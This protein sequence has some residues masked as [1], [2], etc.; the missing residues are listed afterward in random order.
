MSFSEFSNVYLTIAVRYARPEWGNRDDEQM[1]PAVIGLQAVNFVI[2]RALTRGTSSPFIA[3][4]PVSA[5]D[6]AKIRAGLKEFV[7]G[8]V[9][10]AVGALERFPA[11]T[12]WLLA[13]T[14]A[15]NYGVEGEIAAIAIWPRVAQAFGLPTIE[16]SDHRQAIA[17]AFRG[18]ALRYGLVVPA[19]D[20]KHVDM[21]VCQAG[22]AHAQIPGLV[23]AF[24]RAEA[25]FG[26]PPRDD[27]QRLNMWEV[28]AAHSFAFGLS[29]AQKIMVWDE[30]AYHA[31]C[32]AD[33]RKNQ[34][35]LPLAR[36]MAQAI[37]AIEAA[38]GAGG[39]RAIERPRIALVDG[40]PSLVAPADAEVR[41]LIGS[42][43]RRIAAGRS[44]E[45]PAP[46]PPSVT[47]WVEDDN[48]KIEELE[49][50]FLTSPDSIALFDA[51]S[52]VLLDTPPL[53][54]NTGTVDAREVAIAS[55][56]RFRADNEASQQIGSEAHVAFVPLGEGFDI[57]LGTR[58]F[59]V[60]PPMRPRVVVGST[61]IASG[62]G[63]GLFSHPRLIQV[64]FPGFTPENVFLKIEHP[65]L[66]V[67]ISQAVEGDLT[68]DL[69]EVLPRTGPIAPLAVTLS[70]GQGGRVLVRTSQ[71][72]WPGLVAVDGYAFD[73]PNP[74]NLD[75]AR[76]TS[77]AWDG[78]RIGMDA[79]DTTW[80]EAQ[81]AVL[82]QPG[83][84][85]IRRPGF[86]VALVDELGRERAHR[87][88]DRI[89]VLPGSTE[90]LVI[91]TPDQRASLCIRGNLE[92]ASFGTSGMRRLALASLVD[93][94]SDNRIIYVPSQDRG[95]DQ[96]LAELELSTAPKSLDIH[97]RGN[98]RI[99][100][101]AEFASTIDAVRL[102]LES[103]RGE[104]VQEWDLQLGRRPVD[105]RRC[106]GFDGALNGSDLTLQLHEAQIT[107]DCRVAELS[108]RTE[109]EEG[110]RTLR[111]LRG[112][113]YLFLIGEP[114]DCAGATGFLASSAQ[115][116]RCIA[117]ETWPA[118][119]AIVPA[120]K[121]SGLALLEQGR[122]EV[123][124]RAAGLPL[125]P[126]QA[127][128]WVPLCHPIEI[129]A[130]LLSTDIVRF[131][132]LGDE[133]DGTGELA[134]LHRL[135][136]LDRVTEAAAAME[137]APT[138]YL[139][140]ANFQQASTN[141]A[142]DLEGFSFERMSQLS[143]LVETEQ[144]PPSLWRPAE[145]R[146]SSWHHAWCVDRFVER[147]AAAT[148][149]ESSNEERTLRLNKLVSTLPW[150]QRASHVPVPD[151]LVERCQLAEPVA[152][153]LSVAARAWRNNA[154]KLLLRDLSQ[155]VQSDERTVLMD[156]GFLLR[157]APELTAFYL[158]L[159]ELVRM[160]ESD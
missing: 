93:A 6:E 133:G 111:N 102:R 38:G 19:L 15:K 36:E 59:R 42:R 100:V 147:Y 62:P 69:F 22:V 74:P 46:W 110:F 58:L 87:M 139:G 128:S 63:G 75:R 18:A 115:L 117:P 40:A 76:S 121:R 1:S 61:K 129:D 138:F 134:I 90:R 8:R 160:S 88:G 45:L 50:G 3:H 23:R 86:S 81:L 132:A 80:R 34:L 65:T 56:A 95:G 39:G 136:S 106:A 24:M 48:G 140:F 107:G 156:I 7:R 97:R 98:G 44:Y 125:P 116:G 142:V 83:T 9:H 17:S 123:L 85:V 20:A 99:T 72:I 131:H 108:V 78:E 71:W 2:R 52:G 32:F 143:K 127:S 12:A 96:L 11:A 10:G 26:E 43:E 66:K 16:R 25:V 155:R 122:S 84:F 126:G 150:Q 153:F 73:G 159:W 148:P 119:S 114:L 68:I 4:V 137:M 124:L 79:D 151:Q 35:E 49:L 104:Q 113:A 103:L 135:A 94:G 145:G 41:L 37:A 158:L 82:G 101:S 120:W 130:E 57:E 70:L 152:N 118:M 92:E 55:R 105:G 33:A 51:D 112:D 13:S 146:L 31:G 64:S 47:T 30:S 149:N 89:A 29:R 53:S 28:Q 5:Q 21:F 141:S 54:R 60:N 109:G 14:I 67:P 144:R 154:V 77:I 91:R 27:T 157:L